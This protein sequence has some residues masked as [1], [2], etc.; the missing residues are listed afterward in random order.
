MARLACSSY[1]TQPKHNDETV[2]PEAAEQRKGFCCVFR[3]MGSKLQ[4]ALA[5]RQTNHGG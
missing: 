4:K 3:S 2:L 5:R 1:Y